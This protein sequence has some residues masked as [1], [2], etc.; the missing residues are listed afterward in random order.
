MSATARPIEHYLIGYAEH[1]MGNLGRD[2]GMD[3]KRVRDYL[4]S[5]IERWREAYGD[6]VANATETAIRHRWGKQK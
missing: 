1:V 5:C 3:R 2:A 6:T 4:H